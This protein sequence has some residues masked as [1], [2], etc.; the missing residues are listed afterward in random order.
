VLAFWLIFPLFAFSSAYYISFSLHIQ[1]SSYDP[2]VPLPVT[3][4]HSILDPL[5]H[6]SSGIAAVWAAIVLYPATST[7][8]T[9]TE[10]N[11]LTSSKA[12]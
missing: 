6:L 8:Q 3:N 12:F 10:C 1:S 11:P 2:G 9:Y 5:M 7:A 4:T